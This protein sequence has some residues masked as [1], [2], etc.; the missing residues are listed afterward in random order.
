MDGRL[1]FSLRLHLF[2]AANDVTHT[3]APANLI[4]PDR[5]AADAAFI[6]IALLNAFLGNSLR[7]LLLCHP[8]LLS[9]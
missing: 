3:D 8:F 6:D 2:I 7:Y 9:S 5:K 1:T 4:Y